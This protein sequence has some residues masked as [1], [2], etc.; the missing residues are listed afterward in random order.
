M[1][2]LVLLSQ[3]MVKFSK[4]KHTMWISTLTWV[5]NS[6]EMLYVYMSKTRSD[7]MVQ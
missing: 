3:C 5:V 2:E 1:F 7:E 4:N 6:Q